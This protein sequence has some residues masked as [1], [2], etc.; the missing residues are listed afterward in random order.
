M[1][2][3]SPKKGVRTSME[4]ESY[5][6]L[7]CFGFLAVRPVGSWFPD[8]ALNLRLL[9]WKA[10]FNQRAMRDVPSLSLSPLNTVS[11]SPDQ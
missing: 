10:S 3:A 5:V 2:T 8:Q 6:Y 7:A 1:N 11:I 9:H 4:S